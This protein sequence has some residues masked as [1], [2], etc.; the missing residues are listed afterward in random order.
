MNQLLVCGE[1]KIICNFTDGL[2]TNLAMSRSCLAV[3]RGPLRNGPQRFLRLANRS[4]GTFSPSRL[5][6]E[7]Y[8]ATEASDLPG[9]NVP[10]D[11]YILS[12]RED[13]NM[14]NLD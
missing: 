10:N 4:V 2:D 3:K 6:L 14:G 11:L 7:R 1:L 13:P 12:Q 8:Q 5:S 9:L